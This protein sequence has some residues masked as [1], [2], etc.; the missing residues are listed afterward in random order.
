MLAVSL[1]VAA[2]ALVPEPAPGGVPSLA[3]SAT[4][5]S[6]SPMITGSVDVDMRIRALAED[7]G[8]RPRPITSDPLVMIDGQRLSVEAAQAWNSLKAAA[9]AQGH[10]LHLIA[11]YR[12]HSTQRRL[13]LSRLGGFSD[14]A[15]RRCLRWSAPPGYSK[16]HS[17]KAIDITVSG[18]RAGRFATTS[19]YEWLTA[20]GYRNARRFGF[21][22]SYPA[23]GGHYGPDPE[24]WEWI[25]VGWERP[26]LG[27][28]RPV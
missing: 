24:P 26:R 23:D 3:S 15:I 17:A 25:F 10:R 4:S 18:I 19:A 13:F 27:G 22:P 12:D 1:A 11:G 7:R 2:P 9:S 5:S 16:H 6:N 21:A 14:E 20:D 28:T 8:Y